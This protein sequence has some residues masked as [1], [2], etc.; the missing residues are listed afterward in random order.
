[1]K[2]LVLLALV[3][4]SLNV[5]AQRDETDAFGSK[6]ISFGPELN[7][8]TKGIYKTGY[9]VSGRIEWPLGDEFAIDGT[10]GYN[11]F[12]FKNADQF[13]Q[14]AN[15]FVPVKA[16]VTFFWDS[17][18][19]ANGHAGTVQQLNYEKQSSFAYDFG[20]GYLLPIKGNNGLDLGF[21]YER[22]G[23]NRMRE[24]VIRVAYRFGW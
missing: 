8:T 12:F 3:L 13:T 5:F 21:R 11:R 1:M 18:I 24:A 19:Y 23:K 15:V 17:N 14:G 22:W 20:V 7:I 9:G 10:A 2:K 16:G 6:A 4:C